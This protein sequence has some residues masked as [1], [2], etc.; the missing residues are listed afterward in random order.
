M[1]GVL[2]LDQWTCEPC[3]HENDEKPRELCMVCGSKNS[4]VVKIVVKEGRRHVSRVK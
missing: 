1:L 2:N 4:S 3:G